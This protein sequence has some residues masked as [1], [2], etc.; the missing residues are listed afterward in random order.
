MDSVQIKEGEYFLGAN[1]TVKMI[2]DSLI[3]VSSHRNS[4]IGLFNIHSGNQISQISS[5][6]FAEARFFPSSFA[7]EDFPIL[8]IADRFTNS[9]LKFDF[10][11]KKFLEKTKL[12]L[13]ENK[14]IKLAFGQFFKF[15][16]QFLIELTSSN[17]DTFHPHYYIKSGNSIYL[18]DNNGNENF[19]FLPFPSF[20]SET[21]GTINTQ[22]YLASTN[23]NSTWLYSF[24][25]EKKIKRI[26]SSSPIDIIEEIDLPKSRYFNYDLIGLDKIMTFEDYQNGDQTIIPSN[27]EFNSIFESKEKIIIQTWLIGDESKGLNRTTHLMI[28]NKK[29]E[30]WYETSNPRNIL[31]I[32]MLAGEVNDT[33]YFYE[34]SLMKHDEKY[35]K[36]AVLRPIED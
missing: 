35:I 9:V 27:H 23:F 30:K 1:A 33:L 13:P 15:K 21:K 8:Y 28:Y 34:G 31:D 4:A 36:R 11:E 32:G 16:D 25:Q 29:D 22:S 19:S 7:V 14:V 24:P 17:L 10:L 6:D 12:N 26:M 3:A 18:F 2:G 20:Y 5:S